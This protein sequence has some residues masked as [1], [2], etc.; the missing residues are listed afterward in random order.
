VGRY[1]LWCLNRIAGWDL[2]ALQDALRGTTHAARLGSRARFD[3]P[4]PGQQ[5]TAEGVLMHEDPRRDEYFVPIVVKCVGDPNGFARRLGGAMSVEGR[6]RFDRLLQD[7]RYFYRVG[8]ALAVRHWRDYWGTFALGGAYWNVGMLTRAG[9]EGYLGYYEIIRR[10]ARENGE[11][12]VLV[13]YSQGGVVARFLA[14]MDEQLMPPE[15]RVIAGV[16]TV[17]SP[18]HGSPLAGRGNQRLVSVGLL[19]ML[20]ALGGISIV[21]ANPHTRL[22]LEALSDGVLRLPPS[23]TPYRF[24][25]SAVCAVL[26]H[27]IADAVQRGDQASRQAGLLR[28]ARKWLTGLSRDKVR[29]AFFD[30][31]PSGLDDRRTVLG[32][33]VDSPH[34]DV[35]HGAVIGANTSLEDLILQTRPWWQRWA[36]RTFVAPQRFSSIAS[37]Y[38]RIAVDEDARHTP[39]STPRRRRLADLYVSGLPGNAADPRLPAYAHDFIVPSASQAL[40][41]LSPPAGNRFLGNVVNPRATHV[42][43]AHRCGAASDVPHVTRMLRDLSARLA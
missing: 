28:T 9:A 12:A 36:V 10:E 42:S 27:A 18:N 37:A 17:Q 14:W 43:G 33:L 20:T 35:F 19:G 34:Q 32:R 8:H 5:V 31:D 7:Y 2:G 4:P 29:T 39:P 30:L 15:E 40:C 21:G 16:I 41:V 22:A 6:R 23:P 26:D 24:G 38:T 3:D 25:V 13:G 11:K 1:T